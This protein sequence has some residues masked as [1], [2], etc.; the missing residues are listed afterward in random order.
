MIRGEEAKG[1]KQIKKIIKP[2]TKGSCLFLYA[3]DD[4]NYFYFN[5]NKSLNIENINPEILKGHN[6]EYYLEPKLL[7][8]H[9]NIIPQAV[10]TNDKVCFSSS[11]YSVLHKNDEELKYLCALLNSSLIQFYCTFGINNQKS[12]TINLNQYM[13]RHLPIK[14]VDQ[15][16]K[17]QI[18]QKTE[19]IINNLRKKEGFI[20]KTSSSTLKELD[21]IIF[22]I[23]EVSKEDQEIIIS[24]V[25]K[26]INFFNKIYSNL[27]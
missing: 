27:K 26:K 16:I 15:Q 5:K 14:D 2:N 1:L 25:K 21:K 19:F 11:I 22:Q 10:F 8:K 23:Y 17:S 24:Q 4:F 9:N 7:I 18:S 13:I 20:D 12:T 3:K 6:Y